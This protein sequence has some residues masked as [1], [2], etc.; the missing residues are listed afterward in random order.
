MKINFKIGQKFEKRVTRI[1]I[2]VFTVMHPVLS[3]QTQKTDS[4]QIRLLNFEFF[5]TPKF[6]DKIGTFGSGF[7][8]TLC[9][10]K[11]HL[12]GSNGLSSLQDVCI[13]SDWPKFQTIPKP[14]FV[15]PTY[16]LCPENNRDKSHI[17]L[18]PPPLEKS[19]QS[20]RPVVAMYTP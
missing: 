2:T 5:C 12:V 4:G 13:T 11:I 1:Y 7:N 20:G 16:F 17:A 9:T 18:D 19:T 8:T 10:T 15:P 14:N 6:Y 3:L